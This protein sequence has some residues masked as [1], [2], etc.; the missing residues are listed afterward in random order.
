MESVPIVEHLKNKVDRF[1]F[2]STK[3]DH[4]FNS[5]EIVCTATCSLQRACPAVLGY[6]RASLAQQFKCWPWCRVH[7]VVV[8]NAHC[9]VATVVAARFIRLTARTYE[10][11][12]LLP[13]VPPRLGINRGSVRALLLIELIS[14]RRQRGPMK[15]PFSNSGPIAW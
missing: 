1:K 12:A 15:M 14:T 6:L 3:L 8:V 2:L 9:G 10:V 4:L 5:Y 11:E 7:F 13:F